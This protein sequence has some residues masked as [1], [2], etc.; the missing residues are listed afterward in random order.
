MANNYKDS[1][2]YQAYNEAF[3]AGNQVQEPVPTSFDMAMEQTGLGA[4][5]KYGMPLQ[6]APNLNPPVSNLP[7]STMPTTSTTGYDYKKLL[8]P[9]VGILALYLLFKKK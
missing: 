6:P 5:D 2:E 4:S 3:G 7:A 9:A 1:A 8:L